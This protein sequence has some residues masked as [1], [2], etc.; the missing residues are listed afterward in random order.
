MTK[1]FR[2]NENQLSLPFGRAISAEYDNRVRFFWALVGVSILSLF[3]YI[4][5]INSTARL[6]AV[7]QNLEREMRETS[8]GLNSLEF[9]L[10]E[11]KNEV[12]LELAH[13]YGFR[14]VENPLYVSRRSPESLTL[15]T[16]SR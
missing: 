14:E 16:V 9:S 5:A 3:V 15:N 12:T 8:A 4:Y 6:V 2:F 13:A 7:R 11:L 1:K 10:I